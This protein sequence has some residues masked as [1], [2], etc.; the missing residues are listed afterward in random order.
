MA[1]N[2]LK[3][4]QINGF[5]P[6]SKIY[7]V[8]DAELKGFGIRVWPSG[9]KS[10]FVHS[11][12]QG[13][14][15]WKVIGDA[16]HLSLEQAR[17]HARA[18]MAS[19]LPE[20]DAAP[21][22]AG[23]VSFRIVAEEMF[24]RYRMIWKPSTFRV[25]QKVFNAYLLPRFGDKTIA[26]ISRQ[27]VQEWFTSMRHIP[28]VA[29]RSAPVLSVIFREAEA[30]GY[31]EEDSNPC[32]GIKRYRRQGRER[33]LSND[34]IRR[35]GRVLVEL[36][37]AHSMHVAYFRLLLLTGCRCN[38]IR[39]LRWTDY[40]EGKLFLRDSKTGPRTIWLSTAAR[41]VLDALPKTAAW[42]FPRKHGRM[43]MSEPY[44]T[45]KKI[46]VAAN[47]QDF[48]RHDLRH[49]YASVALAHG[50]NL[51]TIG[52]LLGHNDPATTLKYT[53]FGE[54]AVRQA[55]ET[56]GAILQRN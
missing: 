52:K 41:G 19:A 47:L 42:V 53:N 2:R 28:A 9:K 33:F 45:W 54:S 29:D 50:E 43:P 49:T 10:Y 17:T 11:R 31:R 4:Q 25:N 44:E 14:S 32:K 37:Q 15:L 39:S 22:L 6:R 35:F 36:E 13:Q 34:E 1:V 38:E 48:R 18:L 20:L 16:D 56:V 40:R 55:V 23:E 3:Q 26:D 27:D 7:S 46:M 8:R 24:S 21:T 12:R 30:L 5:K 51:R